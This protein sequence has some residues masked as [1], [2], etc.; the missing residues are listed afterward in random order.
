MAGLRLGVDFGQ[1][2]ESGRGGGPHEG[3]GRGA[4]LGG[5]QKVRN[6]LFCLTHEKEVHTLV[7][8]GVRNISDTLWNPPLKFLV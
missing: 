5:V 1:H 6:S 2:R 7:F 4:V 3:L 8:K